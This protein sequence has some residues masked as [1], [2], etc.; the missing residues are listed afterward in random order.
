MQL[1]KSLV[2]GFIFG[3]VVPPLL[4]GFALQL[5]GFSGKIAQKIVEFSYIL[6]TILGKPLGMLE[7]VEQVLVIL[8][9][10]VIWAL[11]FW[12]IYKLYQLSYK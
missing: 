4:L 12:L 10:G 8:S 2:F 9:S 6:S 3:L 11:V 1:H 5:P 7:G